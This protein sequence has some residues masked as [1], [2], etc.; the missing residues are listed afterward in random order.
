MTLDQLQVL[1]SIVQNGSFRAASQKLNRAQSAVSYAIK[2]LE[3]ELEFSLFNRESYRPVLTDRGQAF[4]LK[5]QSLM[6]EFKQLQ[7]FGSQMKTCS[8]PL[9]RITVTLLFPISKLT[10]TLSRLAEKFPTTEVKLNSDVLEGD[11]LLLNSDVDLAITDVRGPAA[12]IEAHRLGSLRMFSV[13]S[14]KHAL[15]QAKN[16]ISKKDLEKYPQ[17]VIKSTGYASKRSSGVFNELNRW[18]VSDFL[19][20]KDLI[21]NGLGWGFMPEFF[22]EHELE[23]GKLVLTSKEPF[24]V[25]IYLCSRRE[26]PLGPAAQFLKERL[27]EMKI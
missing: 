22:V 6:D 9:L 18:T 27:S 19:S 24:L 15:A 13:I 3:K 26:S 17:I 25:D 11:Q 8:E 7:E 20:K 16:K 5:S 4:Y 10:K 14:G 1:I 2:E 21:L 12:K 23:Q